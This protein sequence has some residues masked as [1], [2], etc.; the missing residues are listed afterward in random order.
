[1]EALL[2]RIADYLVAQSWQ[3]TVLVV[4]VG[5]L[6]WVFRHR[7]AHV[8]YLLWLVVLAKCLVPPVVNVP[9]AV[10]PEPAAQTETPALLP[11]VAETPA[12]RPPSIAPRIETQSSPAL[13]A[14]RPARRPLELQQWLV[15]A[16]LGGVAAFVLIAAVKIGRTVSWLR[17]QR[18]PLPCELQARI[19]TLLSSHSGKLPRM[20]LIEGMGQPFV[21]GLVRGD[22]YLPLSFPAS[23]NDEHR[24][25][26]L[27][28][29]LCH[30]WR[31]DAAVNALQIAAQAVFWFHPLVWWAN[32]KMRQEREKACDEMAVAHL[33]ARPKDYS[34]ALVTTLIQAQ[35]STRPVPS[36]AVAGSVK[37]IEE[38]IRAMLR[39]GKKFYQRP[40]LIAAT[41][42]LLAAILTVP[43]AL[44][45]TARAQ[46]RPA[47]GTQK[48][49]S[50][51]LHE[52]V[53]A[54]DLAEVKRLIGQGANV[55]APAG[56]ESLT[57]LGEA[58]HKGHA[59]IVKV[60]LE[61]GADVENAADYF[62]PLFY[63]IWSE[64]PATVKALIAGGADVNVL[65]D[66]KNYPPLVY[67]IWT[68]NASIV[69]VLLAAG[70]NIHTKT[71]AVLTGT[72]GVTSVYWAARSDNKALRDLVL[73]KS[74]LHDTVHL[75][76]YRGDLGEVKKLIA[77]EAACDIRD[78]NGC[79][80]LYWAVLG[81]ASGVAEYLIAEGAD[82]NARDNLG[83]P[84]LLW[85]LELPMVRLLVAHGA[86]IEAAQADGRTR[87][88]VACIHGQRD[89][90]EFLLA[91][92]GD[93]EREDKNNTPPWVYAVAYGHVNMVEF[94]ID[95]G[96]DLSKTGPDGQ[97]LVDVAK[98]GK[99][100]E[101]VNLLR[102][103]GIKESFFGTAR[104]G[105]IDDAKKLISAGEDVNKRNS[106]GQTALHY[107]ARRGGETH[108]QVAEVLIDAG[109][110]IHAK[111]QQGKTPLV[112]AQEANRT[113]MVELLRRHGAKE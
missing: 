88:H 10:L 16:W 8:R 62:T 69:E 101:V 73:A 83:T 22:I 68:N 25:S 24:R 91:K 54:G 99:H 5:A 64:D 18:Q 34:T 4:A 109:A 26:V 98:Q 45:L 29:E 43:T 66:G 71:D 97:T 59:E 56:E 75:A 39:P 9:L 80:P 11:P 52:A 79:T 105:S 31:F 32:R 1:M 48:K 44:V 65:P 13:P 110:D 77:R 38:R 19:S 15:L 7:S 104:A 41:T 46:T 107:A 33:G 27:G 76:A 78:E 2:D 35:E 87:L 21:W 49:L 113:A 36:L 84:P 20:W 100:T 74:D 94:L 14:A 58:A 89:I 28:H 102:Q 92:G 85:A 82:L 93:I 30:V 3:I 53:K 67:A 112:L 81:G 96:V 55:T 95:R 23:G 106:L 70:A 111:D 40:S 17:R 103:H 47:T 37:N 86:D 50:T 108:R 61:S 42:V 90:L 72:K 6:S 57:P 60:L 12:V 51:A 63:A